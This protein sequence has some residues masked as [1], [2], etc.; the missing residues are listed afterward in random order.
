MYVIVFKMKTNAQ[1]NISNMSTLRF[2]TKT[3]NAIGEQEKF[4]SG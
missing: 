2:C 3:T 4:N 1:K